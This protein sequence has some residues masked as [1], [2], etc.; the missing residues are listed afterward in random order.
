[1]ATKQRKIEYITKF[2]LCARAHFDII[3]GISILVSL[4]ALF[5]ESFLN[6]PY[7]KPVVS[8]A[9]AV[10]VLCSGFGV[11]E[12]YR[13]KG[14]LIHYWE[15]KMIKV[16]LPSV[17]IVVGLT[18]A[19]EKNMVSW[20]SQSP[21]GL[22]GSW[23]HLI[24]G[25]YAAFWLVFR[26]VQ[27]RNARLTCLFLCSAAAFALLPETLDI[28]P[29]VFAFPAGVLLSQIGWKYK[30]MKAG[31]GKKILLLALCL[32]AAAVGGIIAA[33]VKLPYAGTLAW[34]VCTLAA[35]LSLLLVTYYLQKI[36]VFGVFAPFGMI[37]YAIYLTYDKV[38]ALFAGQKDWQ[39]YV[40]LVA[41]V[42]VV[43]AVVAWLRQQ[44]INWNQK[45][46]RKGKAHLKGSM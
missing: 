26:M 22:K 41:V 9:A 16:W 30:V 19:L 46:R 4:I 18:A 29:H 2:D 34:S 33:M 17:V 7:G 32:A 36:P 42:F 15:N 12:S 6:V 40:A 35:A 21:V 14:S 1:M 20:I 28:K 8:I 37:S 39:M 3:K 25:E 27:N 31:W 38:F 13:R 10:F 45:M 43:A 24:F 5:C 44:L 11:A 23:L